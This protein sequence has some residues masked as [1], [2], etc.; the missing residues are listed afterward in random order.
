MFEIARG[1]YPPDIALFGGIMEAILVH[2]V[3]LVGCFYD[4]ITEG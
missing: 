2:G 1:G 4:G 3:L